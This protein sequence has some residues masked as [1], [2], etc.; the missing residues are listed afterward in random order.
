MEQTILTPYQ[1]AVL[2]SAKKEKAVTDWYYFTGG[3]ALSEFYLHHRVS[4][5]LDFFTTHQVNPRDTR[6]FV[7]SLKK[8]LPVKEISERRL[9][10]LLMYMITFQDGTILKID[11]NEYDYPLVERSLLKFGDLTIDSLYDIAI[12]KLASIFGRSKAR[13]FVDL[14]FC[15]KQ[16]GYSWEQLFSRMKDKFGLTHEELTIN[17]QFAN[18]QD[19]TDYPR[20]LVPFNKEEMIEFYLAAAKKLEPRIFR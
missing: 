12:N 13:D 20:M 19:V 9:A 7:E 5:D 10:G 4:E 8:D 2:E 6:R 14:F 16:E 18:V 1:S 15:I 17:S 3:T 11:F